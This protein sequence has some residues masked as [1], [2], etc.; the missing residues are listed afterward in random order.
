MVINIIEIAVLN[1]EDDI[2]SIHFPTSLLY[3]KTHSILTNDIYKNSINRNDVLLEPLPVNFLYK[4]E[5]SKSNS[6]FDFFFLQSHK[7]LFQKMIE[8][9][10]GNWYIC[11]YIFL[12]E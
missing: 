5:E 4:S 2:T 7:D 3:Y 9:I 12:R 8:S 11:K 1:F 10:A 6:K